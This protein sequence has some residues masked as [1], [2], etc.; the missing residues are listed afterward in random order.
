M[1]K[2][3]HNDILKITSL[4]LGIL[5][6]GIVPMYNAEATMQTLS[7]T[8]LPLKIPLTMGYVD[9]NEVYYISTEASVKVVI[10]ILLGLIAL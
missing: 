9:G 2:T 10:S 1:I 7:D 5:L 6:L 3:T 8:N 4:A